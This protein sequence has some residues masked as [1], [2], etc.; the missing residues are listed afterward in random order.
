MFGRKYQW[1][2]AAMY[3][4][5]WWE[6]P[7]EDVPCTPDELEEAIHGYIGLDLLP[8]STNENI[9]VS[10]W[11]SGQHSLSLSGR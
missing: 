9:T 3:R 6:V 2:I 7:Q 11:V 8:L 5:K 1:I 4:P 10:G